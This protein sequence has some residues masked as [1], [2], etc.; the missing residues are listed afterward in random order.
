MNQIKFSH[1]WNNKLSLQ[2]FTTIRKSDVQT[3]KYYISKVDEDFDIILDGISYSTC[4]LIAVD[5]FAF[6]KQYLN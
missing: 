3:E 2:Y 6:D 1:N 4:T 5:S